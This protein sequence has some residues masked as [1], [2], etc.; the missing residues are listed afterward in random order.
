LTAKYLSVQK[1]PHFFTMAK[2]TCHDI[3]WKVKFA[4]AKDIQ[5]IEVKWLT[6]NGH[7]IHI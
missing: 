3:L 2:I 7:A 6:N 4:L 1:F 5:G